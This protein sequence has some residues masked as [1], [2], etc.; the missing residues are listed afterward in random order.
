MSDQIDQIDQVDLTDCNRLRQRIAELEQQV[1]TLTAENAAYQRTHQT[2]HESYCLLERF[3]SLSHILTAYMDREFTF[4]R[5]NQAYAQADNREPSFFVGKNHFDLYP[6]TDNEAIFRRVVETGISYT[7]YAKPFDYTHNPERGT[8]YWDWTLQPMKNKTG[9]VEGVLL[10]LLNVTERIYTEG[11]YRA[12]VEH[13]MQGLII[14]QNEQI[15]FANQMMETITG[16]AIDDLRSFSRPQFL[17]ILYYED[18]LMI[19]ENV[20]NL[21]HGH[22]TSM[23]HQ[24]RI[25]RK[26]GAVRWVEIAATR[27]NYYGQ[28][29]IHAACT[30]VTERRQIE[31]AVRIQHELAVALNATNDLTTG[32]TLM[33]DTILQLDGITCG[34]L[35]LAD[36]HSGA[37]D[38]IV[39]R[40]LSSRFI[41]AT[42]HFD[43]DSPQVQLVQHGVPVYRSWKTLSVGTDELRQEG[44]HALAILP[45]LHDNE[46]IAVLNIASRTSDDIPV[47]TRI[48]LEALALQVGSTI[49]RI[50]TQTALNDSLRNFQNLFDSMDDCVF[51]ARVDGHLLHA[52]QAVVRTL[53]YTLDDVKHKTVLDMHPPDRRP[54]AL[55]VFTA[56]A[57]GETDICTVPLQTSNG[58]VIPV[59]TR[60]VD[61]VWN[62]QPVIFGLSRDMSERIRIEEDLRQARDTL[63]QR[64]QE[65]T[66]KLLAS[67]VALNRQIDEREQIEN[68]YRML[69][70]HALQ[71]FALVQHHRIILA[72][73][74]MAEITGYSVDELLASTPEDIRNRVHPDDRERVLTYL[75][76]RLRGEEAPSRYEVR[77]VRKHGD[78]RWVEASVSRVSYKGEPASQIAYVDIT[79][80]KQA[81][82][83]LQS[84]FAQINRS[85][86][87]LQALLDG[88]ND[89]LVLLDSQNTI[90][91]INKAMAAFCRMTQDEFVGQNWAT[92]FRRIV[93]DSTEHLVALRTQTCLSR[94]V[95]RIR[96]PQPDGSIRLLDFRVI[97][98]YDTDQRIEQRIVHSVDV[99]DTVQLHAR[100]IEHE[101]FAASGRLAASVA[102][103]MNTP[104]QA[105]E[106]S[107]GLVRLLEDKDKRDRFLITIHEEV[108]RVGTIVRNLLDLYRPDT[109]H[110][111][112]VALAPLI[113][114]IVLLN[115]SRITMARVTV[116]RNIAKTIPR[117]WGRADELLQVLLNLIINA[118]DA[119][120]N[121]GMLQIAAQPYG[122]DMVQIDVSDTGMGIRPDMCERIFEPFVTTRR[123]GTGLG[124]AISKQIVEQH[125]GMLTVESTVGQGSTFRVILPT[126]PPRTTAYEQ[127]DTGC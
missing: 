44:I 89:G 63:E 77:M 5:V 100:L 103:E 81:E 6:N 92:I 10:T 40:G 107:I 96:A 117:V 14:Y 13:A 36:R 108:T 25:V 72:N 29:A 120:P 59:E 16:Y 51:I 12:L 58:D 17:D 8:T 66:A 127:T 2:D 85:R 45:I 79:R 78:V 31:Q 123:D 87:L 80:R 56:M 47:H 43:A 91:T 122:E 97:T 110:Q 84:S 18:R 9:D 106:T 95:V 74:A 68:A 11:A 55:A 27:I 115:T 28:V 60:T 22:T 53:G 50:T 125:Q 26:D 99:T 70:D 41:A 69:V 101:R 37:L 76:K 52:N 7:T 4:L 65:R 116:Q 62:G 83:A 71:G 49:V 64:V 61:G 54:E 3:F 109:A 86:N 34:G 93:P 88:L 75:H 38:L 113:D 39:H 105:I 33:L 57:Q 126:K 94:D 1:A 124:L 121:G 46:V 24:A 42:T 114:R 119:M 112:S 32:M 118:L 35:Y 104:L 111:S 102:H 67:N 90:Q 20:Y 21:Q 15:L 82:D 30:D 48:V 73:A 98:L 23:N 19:I